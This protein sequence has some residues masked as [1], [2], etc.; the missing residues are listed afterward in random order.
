M[1]QRLIRA[2][3]LPKGCSV[4]LAVSALESGSRILS[5]DTVPFA[6][7]YVAQHPTDYRAAL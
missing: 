1:Q 7:W 4:D 2:H 6:L 3:T 5:E